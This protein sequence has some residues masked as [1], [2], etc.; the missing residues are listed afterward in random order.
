MAFSLSFV[1]KNDTC[2]IKAFRTRQIIT[3]VTTS[4]ITKFNI[5]CLQ[6]KIFIMY[7]HVTHMRVML[8]FNSSLYFEILTK[9]FSDAYNFYMMKTSRH[10]M[11]VKYIYT[12]SI[13]H[14]LLCIM[15][16]LLYRI[17]ISCQYC[18]WNKQRVDELFLPKFRQVYIFYF[19]DIW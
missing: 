19:D 16:Q 5:F 17:S 11:P 10:L 4:S 8:N 1:H 15:I 3:P 12:H 18:Y 6:N 2:L 7:A 9:C 14:Q 13:T